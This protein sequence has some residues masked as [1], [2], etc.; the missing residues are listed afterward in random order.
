MDLSEKVE[1]GGGG[2]KKAWSEVWSA[3]QGV[4]G[5][6][7]TLSVADLVDKLEEEYKSAG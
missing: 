2:L 7:E 1:D 6:D 4:G 3:G 5:I